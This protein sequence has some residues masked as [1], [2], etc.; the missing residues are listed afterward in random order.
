MA[1]VYYFV[2]ETNHSIKPTWYMIWFGRN[3][4]LISMDVV[5]KVTFKYNLETYYLSMPTS[6]ALSSPFLSILLC[7]CLWRIFVRS[8]CVRQFVRMDPVATAWPSYTLNN[9][10]TYCIFLYNRYDNKVT[11]S[12]R[13]IYLYFMNMNLCLHITTT[14]LECW[15]P[16]EV[17]RKPSDALELE[18]HMVMSWNTASGNKLRFWKST[19]YS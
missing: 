5:H 3:I 4:N 6:S 17:R 16:T 2:K 9:F 13:S 15:S 14:L 11:F 10:V 7:L 1:S 18:L 12:F 19:H 8:L